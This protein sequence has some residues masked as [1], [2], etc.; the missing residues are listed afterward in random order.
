LFS[1]APLF[2]SRFFRTGNWSCFVLTFFFSLTGP[3][4]SF[5]LCLEIWLASVVILAE[6]WG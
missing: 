1:L 6:K 3:S 2:L 5:F 4:Q